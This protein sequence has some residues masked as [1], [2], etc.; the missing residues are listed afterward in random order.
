[1]FPVALFAIA[2]KQKQFTQP[3]AE[4]WINKLQQYLHN[5]QTMTNYRDIDESHKQNV[6]QNKPDTK[7]YI[8]Y[9]PIF[10]KLNNM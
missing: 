4:E 6:E 9:N 1:M 10:T 7:E 3:S 5:E 2:P 8:H